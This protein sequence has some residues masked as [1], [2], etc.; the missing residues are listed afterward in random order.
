[1]N[2]A[3]FYEVLFLTIGEAQ[4]AVFGQKYT[5]KSHSEQVGFMLAFEWDK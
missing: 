2:S 3:R 5:L 1:M 4:C